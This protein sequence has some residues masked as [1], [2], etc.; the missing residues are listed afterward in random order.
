MSRRN[1]LLSITACLISD[2]GMPGIYGYGLLRLVQ[3]GRPGPPVW[4]REKVSV[5]S[6]LSNRYLRLTSF[7][8]LFLLSNRESRPIR[9]ERRE[10]T[11]RALP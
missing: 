8:L 6:T 5:S 4:K 7:L 3:A 1:L 10:S 2:I 11:E 9:G